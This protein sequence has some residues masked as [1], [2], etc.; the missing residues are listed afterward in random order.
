LFF[1]LLERLEVPSSASS[2]RFALPRGRS[3]TIPTASS[4][5]VWLVVMSRSYLV[6]HG[7]LHPS[8][9]TKDS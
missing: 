9:W 5:E 6:V 7:P 2:S 1:F 4:P 3:K 8:L